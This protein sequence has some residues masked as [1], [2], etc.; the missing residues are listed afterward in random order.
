MT[1][2]EDLDAEDPATWDDLFV[3]AIDERPVQLVRPADTD[4]PTW[5][6]YD[7]GTYLGTVSAE[8]DGGRP[9]WRVQTTREAHRELADAV[10]ALR[11]PAS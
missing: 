5:A 11:R 1:T 3:R 8:P 6:A 2:V 7:G 9:L 4:R 10:R